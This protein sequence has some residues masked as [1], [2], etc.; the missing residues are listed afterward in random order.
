LKSS[1]KSNEYGC[2]EANVLSDRRNLRV[3]MLALLFVLANGS[4]A[5]AAAQ[6]PDFI[7]KS[8]PEKK[9]INIKDY[10][11]KVVLVTFWA[12]WCGPC[13]QEIPALISLQDV[14]GPQGFSVLGISMD[15]SGARV[16]EKMMEKT[17][18]NYPV[19]LGNNEVSR[20]F[21]GIFGI[22]ASFLVDRSGNVVQR[23]TG[24]VSHDV[25]E[26]DIKKVVY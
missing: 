21:G 26:A 18:I 10:R 3:F 9:E 16:V 7:L 17:K 4:L 22:P 5:Q 6:V 24:W 12:T 2:V 20:A 15:Q 1:E 13:V 14:Y 8:V 11:G 25:L 23:Y 19:V